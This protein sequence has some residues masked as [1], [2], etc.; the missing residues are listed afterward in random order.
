MNALTTPFFK[1]VYLAACAVG[2]FL[3]SPTSE[4]GLPESYR[5][6]WSDPALV[7]AIEKNIEQY[8]KQEAQIELL[9]SQGR[10]I[11]NAT[12]EIQQKTHAFLFGC[13]AFVLGQ[14]GENNAKYEQMFGRL[15][16]FATVPF[17]WEGTE[18]TQGELRYQEG[19]R[20]IW[21]RPPPDRYIPFAKKYGITL[22]GH[23][24]LWHSLNPP[25]IPKDPEQLKK[26]YQKRFSEI[27]QR[28][29]DSI[30]IW[31]VV[32]ESLVCPKTYPLYSPE[33]DYV[34]W[35]FQEAQKVFRPENILMINEVQSV[36]H[37]GIGEK[38]AYFRQVRGLLERGIKIEGIGFQFHFFTG[39]VLQQHL[40]GK[41]YSPDQM[42]KVYESFGE[43]GLPLYITEITIPTTVEDGLEVQAEVLRNL[44]R[45]WF[46]VPRMAG[47]TYWNLADG[48]AY[49]NE[50]AALAGLVDKKLDP[51]PSYLALERLIH[52]EWK[53]RL[54]A[55]SDQE[56][57]VTFRGF[58]G[59]YRI[60]VK[61]GELERTFEIELPAEG[62]RSQ[63]RL[64]VK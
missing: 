31:D 53:T 60:L 64:Q 25:W 41:I 23:P 22:K 19:C 21:R 37:A 3:P 8:R 52:H 32:N 63:H 57:K 29:A 58:R 11:P 27:A 45:L 35:A 42:M 30:L 33:R 40:E 14:L 7:A 18:P 17:Y 62:S 4:A 61:V 13:N 54:S 24:L 20:E 46:S 56:G 10:P 5:K 49:Q 43:L 50:N 16:N 2:V 44:Y 39:P 55:S 47:I 6:A 12:V 1:R 36:S 15:F 51:K 28:Y 59:K 26:L 34:A 48:T 9:D 38:N